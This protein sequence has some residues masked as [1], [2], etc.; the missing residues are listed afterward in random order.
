MIEFDQHRVL[1]EHGLED[2]VSRVLALVEAFLPAGK[3]VAVFTRRD[4][5]DLPTADRDRQLQI[6]TQISDA[7]TSVIGKLP[8]RPSFIVAKG[9]I[10]SSDVGTQALG[11]VRATVLGQ[12]APGVPAWRIGPESRF[13][14]MAYVIFPGNVG[15]V[16]T[17][18]EI[19]ERLA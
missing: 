11:A 13:P 16:D 12:A 1:E 14:G 2:E 4:R 15:G 5:L 17:L 18:R 3:S 10:T 6:S 7:L 8:V 19:V 9:G